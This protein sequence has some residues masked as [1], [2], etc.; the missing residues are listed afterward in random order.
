LLLAFLL[1]A[2]CSTKTSGKSSSGDLE[3]FLVRLG[4]ELENRTG[5]TVEAGESRVEEKVLLLQETSLRCNT[6]TSKFTRAERVRLVRE[7]EGYLRSLA[8]CKKVLLDLSQRLLIAQIAE[9]KGE[10]GTN[11]NQLD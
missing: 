6:F 11:E 4:E 2:F 10:G 1:G 5:F 8:L 7:V 9:E 3:D